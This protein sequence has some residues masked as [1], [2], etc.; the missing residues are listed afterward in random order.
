MEFIESNL[1]SLILFLPV[2]IAAVIALLPSKEKT[3]IRWVA[4][5]GSLV[6]FGLALFLWFAFEPN[7][8][9]FQFEELHLLFWG[10]MIFQT[11]A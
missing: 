10:F 4:L 1:L 5:I 11:L 3:L 8:P 6:V 7:R 9:G 2:V